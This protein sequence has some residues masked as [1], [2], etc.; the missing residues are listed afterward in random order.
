MTSVSQE[1]GPRSG[2]PR[3]STSTLSTERPVSSSRARRKGGFS[4]ADRSPSGSRSRSHR[5][6][7][8]AKTTLC[9]VKAM[10]PMSRGL[11]CATIVTV[12]S[13]AGGLP[14]AARMRKSS[15]VMC[16]LP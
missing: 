12:P 3:A 16:V 11:G 14:S 13:A 2:R 15:S 7:R 4:G 1:G 5:V 10:T 9:P 8:S 6:S